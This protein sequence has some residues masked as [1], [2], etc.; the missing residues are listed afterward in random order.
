MLYI[1]SSRQVLDA[2]DMVGME[3]GN[4]EQI[5]LFPWRECGIDCLVDAVG[6]SGIRHALFAGFKAATIKH[7]SEFV[8]PA[9]HET[10][11]VKRAMPDRVEGACHGDSVMGVT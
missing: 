7:C 6:I 3:M 11:C 1:T 10:F 8:L 9:L 2:V 4:E 5:H